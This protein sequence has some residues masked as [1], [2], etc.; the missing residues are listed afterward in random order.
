[1]KNQTKTKTTQKE[2]K[3]EQFDME[4]YTGIECWVIPLITFEKLTILHSLFCGYTCT[5]KYIKKKKKQQ[6]PTISRKIDLKG[7]CEAAAK[8]LHQELL[9]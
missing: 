8:W 3:G 5:E 4:G 2:I 7:T 1:M 6:Q 9:H